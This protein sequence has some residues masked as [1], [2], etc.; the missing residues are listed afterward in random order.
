MPKDTSS[1]AKCESTE[2]SHLIKN[3]GY[4]RDRAVAA[5]KNICKKVTKNEI[6]NHLLA[7]TIELEKLKKGDE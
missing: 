7:T 2:I 5:A 1:R 6:V 3:K 4:S